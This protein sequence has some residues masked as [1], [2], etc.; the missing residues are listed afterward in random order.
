LQCYLEKEFK[1]RGKK[2]RFQAR[3][4]EKEQ[5]KIEILDHMQQRKQDTF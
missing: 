1:Q 5:T 2:K 3:G 4:A